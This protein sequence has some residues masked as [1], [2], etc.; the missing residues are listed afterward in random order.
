MSNSIRFLG[1]AIFAWAGVR[2]VS[3]G[4][5]PGTQALAF[6]AQAAQ[7]AS[8]PLPAIEPTSLPPIEPVPIASPQFGPGP[9]FGPQFA[10]GSRYPAYAPYPVYI[11][12]PA[13][14]A[15]PGIPQQV[16]YL[17]RPPAVPAEINVFGGAQPAGEWVRSVDAPPPPVPARQSTPSFGE[18]KLPQLPDRLSISSWATMRSQAGSDSLANKGMLG[19]SQAG[20]RLLWQVDPR[21]SASLRASAPVNSQRGVEAALGIRYQ[22]FTSVPVAVTLERRHAF[23]EYG[24]SAFALF[25]E[26]GVYGRP[27]P[28][29]STFDG[30]FQAGVVDF[31]RPDWFVDGQAA[32]SRP[33][34]RNL[35]AGLGLWGG[36]QRGLSRLDAGP[37]ATLRVGTGMRIHLDYRYKLLGNAVPGSG[38]VVTLAGDF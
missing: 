14:A 11:P 33:V 12:V 6:D 28:W 26:G 16:M 20:V 13:A 29:N 36:A 27:M 23:G 22:P 3:L 21:L 1:A 7:S 31:N 10:P 8:P 25:S 38:G 5:I 35:S 4:M 9:M 37:R 30:Y 24:Q 34:W 32:V 2:A 17:D 19:G 15:S 18:L